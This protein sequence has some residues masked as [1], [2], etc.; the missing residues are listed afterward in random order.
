MTQRPSS[1]SAP[2]FDSHAARAIDRAAQALPGV[3][4]YALMQRAGAAAFRQLQHAWPRARRIGI[5]CGPGNN[6]GDGC[7]LA[8]LAR[9]AGCEAH[10]IRLPDGQA[11]SDA[12]RQ[13]SADWAG[14]GGT[15][16]TF[17]GDLPEV[18]VWVDALFGIG[19][20]RAPEGAALALIDAIDRAGL[21]VLALDV[22]SGVDADTGHVPGLAIHAS[23]TLTFIV[24]KCGLHTGAARDHVGELLLDDLGVPGSAIAA[25]A[26]AARLLGP[27]ALAGWLPQRAPDAHKG[28]F[29]H[30]LCVGG[31]HGTA[32][33]VALAAEAALRCG[34]GL[35]SV[36]TRAGHV[37]MLLARRPELMAHAVESA[38]E[39]ATTSARAGLLAVGPGLGIGAWGR[40]MFAGAL[41]SGKPLVLDADA[42]NLLA[43]AP[44]PLPGA[45]L[46]PHPGE[47]GRLLGSATA[48]VQ[49]D[50]FAAAARLAERYACAVVLKGAGSVIAA[51]GMTPCVIDA[52]NPGMATG[53]MGDVLTGV[54]AAL[55]AQGLPPFDA[56][57]CGALL[58]AVAGDAAA[59]QGG[60]RGLLASDL[61]PHLRRLANP[62]A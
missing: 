55:R 27:D 32:G 47:A 9:A 7:V 2:L 35:V 22:P 13:A 1:P 50:R 37:A 8:R 46:T 6:G 33:A 41:A 3:S 59:A 31:D 24:D 15:T 45:V 40:A 49:S 16:T 36:A 61:F 17:E 21:D 14:T 26:P 54:V 56:A 19:L 4:E 30:V 18:D 38:A 52:G 29:G 57:A 5:A 62:C 53:G 42:L 34:A 12:A 39:I 11:R 60:Q 23:R 25:Q 43:A 51:P 10:V 20:A 48:Q 58:H 28:D 44:R